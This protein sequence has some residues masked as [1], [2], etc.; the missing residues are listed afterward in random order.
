MR[1]VSAYAL[2]A[3]V[4]TLGTLASA[5]PGPTAVVVANVSNEDIYLS[6]VLF[7][8]M[9]ATPEML[10]IHN[11]EGPRD[12]RR[13]PIVLSPFL[14][15]GKP[16]T[17][18]LRAGEAAYLEALKPTEGHTSEI[19]VIQ[20]DGKKHAALRYS[21]VKTKGALAGVID[22]SDSKAAF[23]PENR[24]FLFFHGFDSK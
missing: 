15:F 3:S 12:K 14:A 21:V 24:A 23:E 13:A 6:N 1:S 22:A 16:A 17:H 4:F 5:D 20:K 8:G 9:G 11:D 18:L 10:M 7:K 19:A 2:A